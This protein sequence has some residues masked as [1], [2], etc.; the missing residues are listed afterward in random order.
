MHRMNR[1][2]FLQFASG[3]MLV[4]YGMPG[5]ANKGAKHVVI[6]G[7]G[8]AGA[9]MAKYLRLASSALR[10]T[11]IEPKKQY[12]TCFMS[13]EYLGG[14]RDVKSLYFNYTSLKRRG[15]DIVHEDAT[16][17]D[18]EAKTVTT[19]K[20]TFTYDK[21]VV[22]TGIDFNYKS[23]EGMN[24]DLAK[25]IPH[26]W[27]GGEQTLL[28]RKQLLA[29]KNGGTFIM[30]AP[31]NPFRCPPGPYE[32]ASM[33]AHY[34][35]QHKP[36]SKVIVLDPKPKFSKMELFQAG[37]REHYGYETEHSMIE[38]VHQES[39]EGIAKVDAKALRIEFGAQYKADVLNIIPPQ[40][41]VP[42]VVQAGL[43]DDSGWCPVDHGTF[44]S[45]K[46]PAIYV[47]GD[48]AST[49]PMPKSGYIANSQAKTCASAIVASL[50]GEPMPNPSWI[51]TCYSM[52]APKHAISVAMVYRLNQ[53]GNIEEIKDAGGLT[54]ATASRSDLER[55]SIYAHSWFNNI[56]RDVFA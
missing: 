55:E 30:L 41:A 16:V 14:L 18:A 24:I 4:A 19:T 29:M 12:T 25:Q 38:W 50:A 36:K 44:E 46:I 10:I 39:I 54:P 37:W 42:I 11:L 27:Q 53:E 34:L 2:K 51:N 32:R 48:S 20:H 45:K 31:P 9:T 17:I 7:G 56:T 47:I 15:I 49:A 40:K 28:L 26:A 23:I 43:T 33:V 22:A 3:A 52:I 1:R 13:N 35:Q 21:C 5:R 8:I 6:V